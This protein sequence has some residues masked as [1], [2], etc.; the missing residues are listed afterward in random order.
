LA[1]IGLEVEAL[2][3]YNSGVDDLDTQY[4]TWRDDPTPDNL[5][6]V[7]RTLEP[8][9]RYALRMNYAQD[10]PLLRQQ[11]RLFT[12]EAVKSFN[13]EA[14]TRLTT[15]ASSNL[16]QLGRARRSMTN[17]V[18]VPERAQLDMLHLHR[19]ELDFMDKH[20]REPDVSELA[21][22]A[23]FSPDKI[24]VLRRSFRPVTSQSAMG[25]L[26]EIR[27]PALSDEA[28]SYVHRDSDYVDRKILEWKT[29]WKGSDIRKPQDIALSLKLTPSQL[30]RRSA[31][32]ALRIH[33]VTNMLEET[34]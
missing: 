31:K 32:L 11:A 3:R 20:G 1:R 22:A 19:T 13:P 18:K 12:A 7:V 23:R 14:G 4:A 9:T 28:M 30:S 6:Q 10:N 8:V 2:T 21:D 34:T 33:D 25:D 5:H 16:R 24:E 17:P 29:G 15:W 26:S 27:M